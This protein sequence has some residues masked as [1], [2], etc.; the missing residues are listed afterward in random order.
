MTDQEIKTAHDRLQKDW[1]AQIKREKLRKEVWEQREKAWH[2]ANVKY[3]EEMQVIDE[4]YYKDL[5][6]I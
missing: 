5:A 1:T 2:R 3:E 6:A 4:E